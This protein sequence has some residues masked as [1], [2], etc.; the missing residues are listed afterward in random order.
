[1]DIWMNLQTD[2]EGNMPRSNFSY[3]YLSASCPGTLV[4]ED[5]FPQRETWLFSE[6]IW[7]PSIIF[8]R[9]SPEQ[10]NSGW[11]KIRNGVSSA[12]TLGPLHDFS[13]FILGAPWKCQ[14]SFLVFCLTNPVSCSL[15]NQ[16]GPWLWPAVADTDSSVF[17]KCC[18]TWYREGLWLSGPDQ[19]SQRANSAQ[20]LLEWREVREAEPVESVTISRN[21]EPQVR[22]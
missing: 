6:H 21:S 15:T 1:M 14:E 9:Q 19:R 5:D 8:W 11:A 18:H 16:P 7:N 20:W 17:G 13:E 3:G 10:L 12:L 4:E 2:L 22:V